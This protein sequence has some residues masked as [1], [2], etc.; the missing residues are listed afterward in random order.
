[1]HQAQVQPSH[2]IHKTADSMRQKQAGKRV[3]IAA[4]AATKAENLDIPDFPKS[5]ADFKMIGKSTC[6]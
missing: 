2:L 5:D 4:E 6:S 3:A 1:M